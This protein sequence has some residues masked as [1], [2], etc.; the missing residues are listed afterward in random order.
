MTT[1]TS[2]WQ[3]TVTIQWAADDPHVIADRLRRQLACH[4]PTVTLDPDRGETIVDMEIVA[5]SA[6]EAAAQAAADI[7]ATVADTGCDIESVSA[8]RLWHIAADTPHTK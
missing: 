4:H 8:V 1:Q 2:T 6:A 7:A 3:T 5:E